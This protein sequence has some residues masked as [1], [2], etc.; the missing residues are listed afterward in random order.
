MNEF[1]RICCSRSIKTV[2]K[3]KG[4]RILKSAPLVVGSGVVESAGGK[5]NCLGFFVEVMRDSQRF[6]GV[7]RRSKD[8]V[9]KVE[10][11][12]ILIP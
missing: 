3:K 6:R 7:D 11:R 9:D 1:G 2:C 4:R 12:C 10:C 5:E 8:K